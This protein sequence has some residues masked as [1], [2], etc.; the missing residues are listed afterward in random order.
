M[1][2]ILEEKSPGKINV[3]VESLFALAQ[4]RFDDWRVAADQAELFAACGFGN[5]GAELVRHRAD[6]REPQN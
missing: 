5:Y 6:R 3:S 4:D 2:G 1:V